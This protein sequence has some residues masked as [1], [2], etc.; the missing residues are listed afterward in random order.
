ME[1][2]RKLD[3]IGEIKLTL[4]E[5]KASRF[6]IVDRQ[7]I[8]AKKQVGKEENGEKIMDK[9]LFENSEITREHSVIFNILNLLYPDFSI[10][11]NYTTQNDKIIV[12]KELY[13]L[14]KIL[15]ERKNINFDIPFFYYNLGPYSNVAAKYIGDIYGENNIEKIQKQLIGNI[16]LDHRV[17]ESVGELKKIRKAIKNDFNNIS[18][19]LALCIIA[20]L[21]Y[22]LGSSAFLNI[23]IY[24]IR[25]SKLDKNL[26]EIYAN[27]S[28]YPV[29]FQN[30]RRSEMFNYFEK[31]FL[32]LKFLMQDNIESFNI[33]CTKNYI[34]AENIIIL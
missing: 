11:K 29:V 9:R 34:D 1:E 32:L 18:Y 30:I 10:E 19:S 16:S 25:L 3:D 13:I 27:F 8:S 15:R 23:K 21:L 5:I 12:Q 4:K 7:Q 22:A 24:N 6:Y 2:P 28:K 33:F 26:D 20:S 17:Y 14:Y 31:C